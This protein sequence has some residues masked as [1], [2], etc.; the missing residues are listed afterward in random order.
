[1]TVKSELWTNPSLCNV[2]NQITTPAT[3][4]LC[5][6]MFACSITAGAIPNTY[7]ASTGCVN[8]PGT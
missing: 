3:G 4:K 1:M 8:V 7:V 2:N 6:N 5:T